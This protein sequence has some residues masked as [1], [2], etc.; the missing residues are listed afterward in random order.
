MAWMS[1]VRGGPIPNI[2]LQLCTTHI[3][4]NL[5]A[6]TATHFVVGCGY[7][8]LFSV[9]ICFEKKSVAGINV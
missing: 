2:R 4:T 1:T 7:G 9:K 3:I 6:L 5:I 8:H